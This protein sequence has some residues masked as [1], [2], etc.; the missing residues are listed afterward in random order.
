MDIFNDFSIGL[1]AMQAFILIVLIFLLGKFA[2]KPILNAIEG[3]EEGIKDALEAAENAKKEMQNLQA[4][5]DRLLKEARA[6]R[7]AMLKEAREI[8]DK[9]ISDSKEQ[10]QL[11]GDKIIKQA[12]AAI[13]GEKKAALADIKNQVGSLSVEIAEKVIKE[14][15]SD[16]DKQ[17]KLVE[18]LLGDIK[19]N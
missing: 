12:Q 6:E 11:E 3:R 18:G 10:A 4:D 16:K 17:L 19:L 8:K 9:M 5:N 1:F 13:E 14:Q 7:E 15:L 2:W